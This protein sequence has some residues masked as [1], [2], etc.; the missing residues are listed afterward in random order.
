MISSREK[1]LLKS[2][3]SDT[4]CVMS[5][6]KWK[7]SLVIAPSTPLNSQDSPCQAYGCRVQKHDNCMSNSMENICAFVRADTICLKTP[8]GWAKQ[9]EKLRVY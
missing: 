6:S 5:L 3:M 7:S 9:Y 2:P 8:S 4:M 1:F